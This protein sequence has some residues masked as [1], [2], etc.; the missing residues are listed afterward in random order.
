MSVTVSA[1]ISLKDALDELGHV[2]EQKQA[3]AKITFNYA[4]SGTLQHQ[5]QEGAPVDVFLS[6]AEQ[7]MDTLASEGLILAGTRRD[8]VAN[9]LVLIVP[10]SRSVV[11][12]FQDLTRAE[13]KVIAVGEPATVPAG[14]YARQTFYHLGL[15]SALEKKFVYAKD[16]RQVLTYVETANADAGVVYK[17]DVQGSSK[18]RVVT[19]APPD[20]HSPI[21]YPV[22]IVRNSNDV[23]AA[24]AFLEFLEGPEACAVF[25]KF[26][27]ATPEKQAGKN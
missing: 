1:A 15:L 11:K 3:G 18:V 21:V 2:Y 5:I 22:A 8:L 19:T 26:G 12:G 13:V 9:N 25:R 14:M 24:R 7:Q 23:A 17:T 27:F 6:A 16:V 20:S 4:S 10:A